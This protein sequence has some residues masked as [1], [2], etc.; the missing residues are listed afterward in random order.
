MTMIKK[1]VVY[2]ASLHN[3]QGQEIQTQQFTNWNLL[4]EW[5]YGVKNFNKDRIL[6]L[7]VRYPDMNETDHYIVHVNRLEYMCTD[8]DTREVANA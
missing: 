6:R 2:V 7:R 3:E 1:P 8:R 4:K 5:S